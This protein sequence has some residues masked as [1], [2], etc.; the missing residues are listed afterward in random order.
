MA[1]PRQHRTRK[2]P[3]ALIPRARSMNRAAHTPA[4]TIRMGLAPMPR[5]PTRGVRPWTRDRWMLGPM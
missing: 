5:P 3:S 2:W 4:A 1:V